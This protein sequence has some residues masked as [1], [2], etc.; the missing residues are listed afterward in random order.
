MHFSS[1]IVSFKL[2]Y[3]R[4]SNRR[5][6]IS[7]NQFAIKYYSNVTLFLFKLKYKF[8]I[9]L[10]IE[11][12]LN[13]ILKEKDTIMIQRTLVLIVMCCVLFGKFIDAFAC[14]LEFVLLKSLFFVVKAQNPYDCT[15]KPNGD[16]VDPSAPCSGYFYKCSNEYTSYFV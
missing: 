3:S 8:F 10:L 16:Y 6:F 13:L 7:W 12:E 5:G 4:T 1:K 2:S 15:G 9:Y 14:W 11:S